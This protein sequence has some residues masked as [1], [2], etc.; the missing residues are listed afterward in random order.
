M[1]GAAGVAGHGIGSGLVD[2]ADEM[3]DILYEP[4]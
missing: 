3:F 4:S 1:A 2:L